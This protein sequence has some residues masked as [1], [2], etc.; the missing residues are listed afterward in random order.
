MKQDR[1]NYIV[2]E[3]PIGV[4]KTTLAKKKLAKTFN[5]DLLLEG[6]EENP[7][8]RVFIMIQR[9]QLYQHSFS[10]FFNVQDKLKY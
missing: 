2:V 4:G 9:M 5:T 10:F 1:P 7:F 3:G 6:A 8:Y